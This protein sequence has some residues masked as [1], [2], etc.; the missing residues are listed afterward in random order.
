MG[1]GTGH[2]SGGSSSGSSGPDGADGSP[3][4]LGTTAG[5]GGGGGGG[6]PY[7]GAGGSGGGVGSG[8]G[9]GGGGGQSYVDSSIAT[10]QSFGTANTA[11]NGPLII[12]YTGPEG[13][14]QTFFC[15]GT[16]P[17][18]TVPEGAIA[19][20]VTAIGGDGPVA[21]NETATAGS[22]SG[23]SGTLQV[24]PGEVLH[25]AVGCAGG[26]SNPTGDHAVWW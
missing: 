5:A 2:G 24:T 12:S 4:V 14:P 20:F 16:R 11:A 19:L 25:V 21:T 9:G 8:G 10:D 6:Y 15:S 1:T 23:R 18:Y 3:P 22:K 17:D 13:T 7:G 26:A